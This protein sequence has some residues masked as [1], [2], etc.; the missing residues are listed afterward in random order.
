MLTLKYSILSYLCYK[1]IF[2]QWRKPCYTGCYKDW[3]DSDCSKP[4]PATCVGGHCY[5]GNGSCVWGCNPDN[6]LN[7]ICDTKHKLQSYI[8]CC[9]FESVCVFI[10]ALCNAYLFHM[11]SEISS[12]KNDIVHRK[13]ITTRWHTCY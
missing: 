12:C 10:P 8:V 4:C 7:D 6:C 5:P 9:V 13:N 11:K 3:W 1:Y 2:V